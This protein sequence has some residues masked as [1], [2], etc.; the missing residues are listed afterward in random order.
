MR[1]NSKLSVSLPFFCITLF[2]KQQ[3]L[4]Y[5]VNRV[6]SASLCSV[7]QAAQAAHKEY[8]RSNTKVQNVHLL[9]CLFFSEEKIYTYMHAR[10]T[11]TKYLDGIKQRYEQNVVCLHPTKCTAAEVRPSSNT[12]TERVLS[13]ANEGAV[14]AQEFCLWANHSEEESKVFLE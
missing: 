10:Q 4:R 9:V 8:N 5:V 3:E 6:H 13:S 14:G 1:P 2:L 11:I 7:T 12:R